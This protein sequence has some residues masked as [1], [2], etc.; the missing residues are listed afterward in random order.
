MSSS[1]SDESPNWAELAPKLRE[2]E[3]VIADLA[4]QVRI[5]FAAGKNS[6]EVATWLQQVGLSAAEAQT[7]MTAVQQAAQQAARGELTVRSGPWDF[8]GVFAQRE[9]P[10]AER[11]ERKER[12]EKSRHLAEW[13][14]DPTFDLGGAS[15]AQ[16]VGGEAHRSQ[17]GERLF[18]SLAMAA[19]F[20]PMLVIV[21]VTVLAALGVF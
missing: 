2:Q 7:L 12:R 16:V 11:R 18:T 14:P 3:Q 1:E 20:L 10:L 19:V 17:R 21:V 15:Y 9:N 6:S 13:G 8:R 4:R 5:M